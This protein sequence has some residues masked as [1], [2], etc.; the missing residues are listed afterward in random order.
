MELKSATGKYYMDEMQIL[1][2]IKKQYDVLVD[3][4]TG[5]VIAKTKTQYKLD[6]AILRLSL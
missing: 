5:E 1:Q 6:T 4:A 2:H 3:E